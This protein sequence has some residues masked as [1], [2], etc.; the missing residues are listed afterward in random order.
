MSNQHKETLGCQ[1]VLFQF[2]TITNLG[3]SHTE[4]LQLSAIQ[5]LEAQTWIFSDY[6]LTK[7]EKHSFTSV[8]ERAS[9]I[10]WMS[11][12]INLVEQAKWEQASGSKRNWSRQMGV[13]KMGIGIW[14]QAKWHQTSTVMGVVVVALLGYV[15]I[16]GLCQLSTCV[17][18]SPHRCCDPQLIVT[19]RCIQEIIAIQPY[20]AISF[21]TSSR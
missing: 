20:R 10:A 5:Q 18:T 11:A 19:A 3:A 13:G 7:V 9:S 1:L 17:L 12:L 8:V 16:I 15:N 6:G 4:L 2:S 21:Q 14:N